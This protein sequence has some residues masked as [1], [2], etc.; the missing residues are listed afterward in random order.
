VKVDKVYLVGFMGAGKTTVARTL[1]RRLGWRA[2]DIDELVEQRERQPIASIFARKGE[3]YFRAAERRVL[4]DH[5]PIR[6]LVVATGGGTFVDPQNRAAI[7]Q[8][9]V[10]VWLDLPIEPLIARVRRIRAA[11]HRAAP[12][13]CRGPVP[14]GCRRQE[15]R[16][17]RRRNRALAGSVKYLVLT[18]IHANMEAL[19]ACL[20][21]AQARGYDE[22]L[23]L[24]DLI[25]YGPD[26]NAVSERI[27]SL[28][29]RA[30]VRGNHDKVALGLEQAEGFNPAARHAA[31]WTIDA[32]TPEN[33]AWVAGL[34]MGPIEVDDMV[35]VCH[36]APFDEDSYVFDELDAMRALAS[37]P[38]PV[39]LFGHTHFAIAF[40]LTATGL[41][42][43]SPGAE[44]VSTLP[45][46]D[47]VR[48]L[49]NPGSVGQPRDANPRAAYAIVDTVAKQIAMCRVA[50]PVEITQAKMVR[51][52]LPEPLVR[53]LA[54][55][56]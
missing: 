9:G 56:R 20:S 16:R 18:D 15:R 29:P 24:G 50:Y 46:Q 27:R 53:R 22:V 1:A 42:V 17:D 8:D 47:G 7:K 45:L 2:V 54:A 28:R 11:V 34:P 37:S 3:P 13:I 52:G 36:G 25:G 31:H 38:R 39:C 55:G 49:I 19:E 5:I 48:Y 32:L 30:I 33:R 14:G 26:P 10:S 43:A 41:S 51:A 35:A 44:G 21:D 6:H 23:V 12:R 4:L 40:E